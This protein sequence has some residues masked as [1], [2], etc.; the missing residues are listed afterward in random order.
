VLDQKLTALMKN[1]QLLALCLGLSGALPL[2]A[3]AAT[4]LVYLGQDF[5]SAI[6]ASAAGDTLVVQPGVY[7]DANLA[8]NKP[9]TV[10]PTGTNGD[11]I[12]FMGTVS[13]SG[14]GAVTFQHAYFASSVQATAT[15]TAFFDSVFN[16]Q[17]VAGGGKLTMK[18]VLLN[19]AL[20]LTNNTSFEAL[21]LTNSGP[22][23]A[24]ATIGSKTPLVAVQSVFGNA[25]SLTGYSVW[26]GYNNFTNNG[27]SGFFFNLQATNCDSVL[28]GNLFSFNNFG[29]TASSVYTSGGA[30]RAY[31]NLLTGSESVGQAG[32][33]AFNLNSTSAEIANNTAFTPYL[34]NG[35]KVI[36]GVAASGSSPITLRANIFSCANVVGAVAIQASGDASQSVLISYCDFY[37]DHVQ[38]LISGVSVPPVNCLLQVNPNVNADGS[39]PAGSPCLNAGPPD[40]IYNNRD[41]TRNTIGYTGGPY[42]NPANYTNSNPMV[43]L[44]TGQQMVMAGPQASIQ[45]NTAASAGH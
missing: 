41:G 5:Q 30:L 7:P 26:L 35:Y 18:R 15:S 39:L 17:V 36:S 13:V 43:F 2:D 40:A 11:M 34:Y 19:S 4:N 14:S 23:V 3:Y 37:D 21:R 25:V 44:L 1:P 10:L 16:S 22:L 24:T 8:F 31:N 38:T 6:N 9:L 33:F 42:F 29:G 32:V 28:I 45:V 20:T 12:Q 27:L